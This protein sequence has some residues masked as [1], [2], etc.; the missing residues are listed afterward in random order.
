LAADAR[1]TL[2]AGSRIVAAPA[3]GTLLVEQADTAARLH[4]RSLVLCSGA[5][6]LLLPFPGWTLPGVTGAGGLQ[7]LIKAGMPVQGERTV[8]AG[9]GP[10]L[11]AAAATAR[12]HGALVV[13]IAEQAPLARVLRF[14]SALW[15]WPG[16]ALQAGMLVDH[17]YRTGVLVE[18]ALGDD[19]LR[20]VRLRRGDRR[21]ELPCDRLAC[22]FGL[23]PDTGLAALLGCQIDP[24]SDAIVV[25]ALQRT[26]MDRI[27]AA[28]ECTGIGGSELALV[29]G[30]IAGH[31]S[32]ADA[33]RAGKLFRRRAYW[34]GFA[35]LVQATFVLDP[36]HRQAAQADTLVCRCEDV[37]LG[38]IRAQPDAWHA[39]MQSR[40]GMG[41]CQ[42]RICASAARVLL[43]WPLPA[44]RPPLS[45]ARIGTLMLDDGPSA[46]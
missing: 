44:P 13:R 35:A 18:A 20:A 31:A 9:S 16:K 19:R 6:E 45:P 30:A 38:A 28:G 5:R 8:I 32:A 42:G 1:I 15:R 33:T 41:A 22:G 34:R 24:G 25:D 2:F 40:C 3:P 12:R 4:Y 23:V 46:P 10:L 11:L 39:R 7:A 17:R 14:G 21:V 29:E 37:P 26:S 43:G 36:A 27:Y